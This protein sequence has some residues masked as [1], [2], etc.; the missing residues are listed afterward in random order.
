MKAEAAKL[1]GA[2][3]GPKPCP[4]KCAAEKGRKL[5]SV[6]FA[7]RPG[8]ASAKGAE[9]R[10]IVTAGYDGFDGGIEIFGPPEQKGRLGCVRPPCHLRT[11][12]PFCRKVST[13]RRS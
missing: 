3:I 4:R 1:P 12:I 11:T 8:P 13:P 9:E 2:G 5:Y 6:R 10:S 7:K